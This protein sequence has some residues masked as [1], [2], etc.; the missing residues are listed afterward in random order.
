M[1]Q[2]EKAPALIRAGAVNRKLLKEAL[3]AFHFFQA[4]RLATQAAQIEEF[5]APHTCRPYLLDFVDYLGV[6][7]ENALDTLAEAH[8]AHRE[9]ALRAV[10]ESNDD[11][12]KR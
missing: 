6:E 9:A 3:F 4:G 2:Q 10:L 11:A 8:L 5:G 12:L 7:R 1:G